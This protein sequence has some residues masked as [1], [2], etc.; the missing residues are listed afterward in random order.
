LT[1][2]DVFDQ[3]EEDGA[4]V[5]LDAEPPPASYQDVRQAA[6]LCPSLAITI[7]E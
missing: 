4:V 1:A 2:A 5:L 7:S 3:R 6:D